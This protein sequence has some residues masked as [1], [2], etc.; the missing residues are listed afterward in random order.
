[1]IDVD[2][3]HPVS[4]EEVRGWIRSRG[5]DLACPICGREEF[6]LDEV[7]IMGAGRHE[8]YGAHRLRRTQVVCENCGCVTGFDLERLRPGA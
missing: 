5:G 6:A 1:V 7:A 4:V 2:T 3:A 8:G